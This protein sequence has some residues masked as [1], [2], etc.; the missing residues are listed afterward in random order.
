MFFGSLNFFLVKYPAF[1]FGILFPPILLDSFPGCSE[2]QI[3]RSDGQISLLGKV[4]E[5]LT[6]PCCR[7][8]MSVLLLTYECV[9]TDLESYAVLEVEAGK[10]DH[11]GEEEEEEQRV[12]SSA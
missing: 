11:Q 1:G 7:R 6:S 3:S 12:K 8:K 10:A 2:D 5:R 4:E 9:P